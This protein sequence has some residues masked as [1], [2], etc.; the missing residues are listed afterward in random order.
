MGD[1]DE[2]DEYHFIWTQWKSNKILSII[3]THTDVT[4]QQNG[5]T[6]SVLTSA[7]GNPTGSESLL[8]TQVTT[9]TDKDSNSS[10][11]TLLAT[12]TRRKRA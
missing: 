3:K 12:P 7:G 6:R 9:V 2:W 10:V 5:D 1:F 11:E 8:S 4:Q